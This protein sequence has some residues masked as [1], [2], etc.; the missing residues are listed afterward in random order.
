MKNVI[1]FILVSLLAF[2]SCKKD[3]NPDSTVDL[4]PTISYSGKVYHTVKIGTQTWL[5]E[6][7]NVGVMIDSLQNQSNNG[8]IEKY[9]YNND[10]ANC[11]KYGGLYQWNEAMA[12]DTSEGA[13]GICPT[14]WHIPTL[15]EFLTLV[16]EVG[17]DGN[18]L[19]RE[20]QGS[21][22]GV[23]TNISGFSA[24]LAGYRYDDGAFYDLGGHAFFWSSTE[25][26]AP[27]AYNM[28]LWYYDSD[29]TMTNYYKDYGFSIR[30]LKD[31]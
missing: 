29:L 1:Y 26:N 25:Y 10:T 14:G 27:K 8:T 23:G 2:T 24:L 7:L 11:N 13:K 19:K 3:S 4:S 18:K 21:G 20:D 28:T 17:N 16:T 5:K 9:C 6:N 15:A 30:C 31:N 12:Y 22:S